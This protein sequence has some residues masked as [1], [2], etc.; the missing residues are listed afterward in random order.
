MGKIEAGCIVIRNKLCI[1][2]VMR[3]KTGMA[4]QGLT[5]RAMK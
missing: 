1:V 4:T 5:F 2:T 3:G